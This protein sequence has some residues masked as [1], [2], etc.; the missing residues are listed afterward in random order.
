MLQTCPNIIGGGDGW[1][2]NSDGSTQIKT[3]DVGDTSVVFNNI[4]TNTNFG[5]RLWLDTSTA[6]T[7]DTEAPKQIGALV[8]DHTNHT[9]TANL[10]T[11]TAAQDGTKAKLRIIR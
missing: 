11:V 9:C 3:L 6:S 2:A 4:P 7:A 5:Y 10:T 1:V 8:F